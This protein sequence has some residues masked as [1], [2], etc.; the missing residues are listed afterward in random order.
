MRIHPLVI[1]AVVVGVA[2]GGIAAWYSTGVKRPGRIINPL[3]ES[4]QAV[5]SVSPTPTPVP[6]KT[7][8]DNNNRMQFSYPENLTLNTHP[9]DN[10]NYAHFEF[11]DP[12]HPGNLI[13]WVRDTTATNLGTWMKTDKRFT[14]GVITDANLGGKPAKKIR[15]AGSD[16]I[17]T[18]FP[19]Q[20]IV[21][22]VE[23]SGSAYWSGI[24]DVVTGS[25]A[26]TGAPQGG[27]GN[28]GSAVDETAILQ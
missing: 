18:G 11:T 4:E 9:E 1:S 27:S 16:L 2:A 26:F 5:S 10:V 12:E 17:I 15:T 13:V 6:L 22:T 21:Y 19:D 14:D 8:T 3:A 20:G 25:F 7:L 23:A 24:S 28:G